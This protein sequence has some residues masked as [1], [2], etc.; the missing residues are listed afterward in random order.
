MTSSTSYSEAEAIS[1]SG[2]TFRRDLVAVTAVVCCLFEGA[3]RNRNLA[4]SRI[5]AIT[6]SAILKNL[7]GTGVIVTTSSMNHG[8]SMGCIERHLQRHLQRS[9]KQIFA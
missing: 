3:S 6:G 2:R 4:S 1:R 8:L 7:R 9:R 5:G